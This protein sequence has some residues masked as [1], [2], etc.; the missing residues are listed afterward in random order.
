M[1]RF[2]GLLLL[3]SLCLAGT[4]F[5]QEKVRFA[6]LPMENRETVVKQFRPLTDFLQERLGI[7]IEYVYADSY[8]DLLKKFR[9]GE[10]DLAYQGPLP[11]VRLRANYPQAEPLVHF[12]EASGQATY[13]CSLVAFADSRPDLKGLAGERVAL[14]QSLSTCGYLSTNGLLRRYGSSLE[15]NRYRYLGTHDAVAL[16]VVRGEFDLGGLKTAIARKYAHMGLSM[17]TET[18]PLPGFALVANKATLKP[19]LQTRIRQAIVELAPQGDDKKMLE[20][21]GDNIRYGAVPA[22]DS[23]YDAVRQ[24]LGGVEIPDKGNF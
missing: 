18:A 12:K 16:G 4:S 22:E 1:H 23:H 10:I 3:A 11:Y 7:T 20:S 14:T 17:L 9:N 6:P 15:Q 5:A 24:L 19:E 21:W 13:T 8:N 2:V